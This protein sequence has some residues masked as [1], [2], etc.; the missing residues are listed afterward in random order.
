LLP[1]SYFGTTYRQPAPVGRNTFYGSLAPGQEDVEQTQAH[2]VINKLEHEFAPGLKLTNTTGYS[3]VDRFNRT[4]A[5]QITGINTTTS[6]LFNAAVGGTRLSTP[7][8][9][10]TTA[11]ALNNIWVANTNHYQNQTNNR[12]I[13]NVTDLNAQF[14]T[15]WLHHNVL[16]G[17]E[18]SREDRENYR[19][20]F[21]D[22]YR[23]NIGNPNPYQ[24]G[25]LN[26]T[27][28]ATVS[29]ANSRGFYVQDQ[30]KVT[31]WLE[32]LGGIRYDVFK[33]NSDTFSFNRLTGG[34][35]SPAVAPTSLSSNNDFLSYRAGVVLHPT[36]RPLIRRPKPPRSRTACRRSIPC[37]R[38]STKSAQ[39]PIC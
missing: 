6:N 14:A 1:G 9:P 22:N 21:T 2:T 20:T 16:V 28:A 5:V 39:R 35:A 17:M 34:P 31:E 8:A 18:W 33:A 29:D 27:T 11:T 37:S 24:I 30:M 12:L 23:V 4:R 7:G 36:A 25:T 26:P 15:G 32:L 10:L 13:S 19:T 38:K 3:A